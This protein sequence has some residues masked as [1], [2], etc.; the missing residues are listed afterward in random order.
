MMAEASKIG[1]VQVQVQ[2]ES[3]SRHHAGISLREDRSSEEPPPVG[4]S[5]KF[6]ALDGYELGGVHFESA[7]ECAPEIAVVFAGGSGILARRYRH[8]A[9]FLASSGIPVLTFD[10][11]GIG[12]SRPRSLRGFRAT[13]EDW[14]ECDCGGAIAWMRGRYPRAK[15]AGVAHSIGSLIIGGAPNVR[16]FSKLVFVA[17]HTGYYGDY[18][19]RNRLPMAVL[20]HGVMP[21][22]THLF[23]YFPARLLGLGED[24]PAGM[25][26]QWAARRTPDLRPEATD[27]E[28]S[29][30]RA[31]LARFGEINLPVYALSFADDAFATEAGAHRLVGVYSGVA[32]RYECVK[33]DSVGLSDIGHFG[34]FRRDGNA[35][36]WPL[37]LADLRAEPT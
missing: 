13:A 34:F 7:G 20:W 4:E 25:A 19:R 36:L 1:L 29:R 6:P 23:G 12:R 5:M 10:Y 3:T 22:L 30:A 35:R 9:S 27:P 16:E 21:V 15:L 28:A 37:V 33:P 31:M 8:F 26:L 17:A 18:S 11:R 2:P 32:A 24:I 14:S